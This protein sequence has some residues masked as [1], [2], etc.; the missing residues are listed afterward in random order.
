MIRKHILRAIAGVL[1]LCMLTGCA[2]DVP[3]PIEP[4]AEQSITESVEVDDRTWAQRRLHA[5]ADFKG[6]SYGVY[7]ESL[8]MLLEK[9]PET[10]RFVLEYPEKHGKAYEIDLSE[11]AGSETVP[12]FLQWDQR[13]GYI[14]YGNDVAGITACGP[15]CLSMVAY[16]LTGDED[17]SP[18][19]IM[20]FAMD[21][22]YCV[23]GN[24][25]RW[26]LIS[27]GAQ[28]LGLNVTELPLVEKRIRNE[29][30]AGN[31]VVCVMGPGIFT[32]TGHFIVITGYENGKYRV[33]DPNSII[34]SHELWSF[35]Q[36]Q[37]QIRN[38]WA[39]SAWS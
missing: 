31:P 6:Y 13:W 37:D 17:M 10:I 30:L 36:I 28:K 21:N 11:Y 20:Q 33:N 2:Q 24:G 18:D 25:S 7:P 26:T 8:R 5:Y 19:R 23:P 35:S 15:L 14:T 3:A 12:L 9:N 32:T 29:V 27:Q 39:I 1:L 4:Q 34:R 16:Y 22:G 38:L